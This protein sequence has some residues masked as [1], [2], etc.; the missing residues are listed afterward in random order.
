MI[1]TMRFKETNRKNSNN[2][3][4]SNKLFKYQ[5]KVLTLIFYMKL[6]FI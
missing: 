4:N 3:Q 6:I 2:E 5:F 1:S